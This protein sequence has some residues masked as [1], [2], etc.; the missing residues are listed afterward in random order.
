MDLRDSVR[1]VGTLV[2]PEQIQVAARVMSE[3]QELPVPAGGTVEKGD[4]IARLDD[5]RLVA[6]K[7]EVDARVQLTRNTFSR[8]ERLYESST[9]TR[10]ELDEA[11]AALDQALASQAMIE[12]ELRDTRI[13]A[14]FAGRIGERQVS[15]GQLVQPG[16]ILFSL[17]QMD[18]LELRME[19]PERFSSALRDGMSVRMSSEA[20]PG[21]TFE[22][23]LVFLS[24]DVNP[25]TRSVVV[26]AQM[27]NPEEK[28]RPG[29]FGQVDLVLEERPE[30]LVIPEAAVMQRG[31][32]TMVLRK[33]SE[34]RADMRPVE[35]GIRFDG[36]MEIR[37]GLSKDDIVVVEGLMKARPGSL[38]KLGPGSER[39]GLS[40]ESDDDENGDDA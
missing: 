10:Q 31:T 20:F 32:Q 37:S 1:L 21:D 30:A 36:M 8:L 5:A 34:G 17:T 13:A 33:N 24:P 40:P 28:L 27:A 9:A 7:A 19:V 14:P 29:M 4:L 38:L 15:T 12:E 25:R 6:R 16:Q 35:V 3:I 39:F 26:R 11:R 18:P 2:P 22:G 23:K